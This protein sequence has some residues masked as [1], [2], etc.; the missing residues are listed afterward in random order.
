MVH[1]LRLLRAMESCCQRWGSIIHQLW[2][3]NT[4][5]HPSRIAGRSRGTQYYPRGC[6]SRYIKALSGGAWYGPILK[7]TTEDGML[8]RQQ[9]S[10]CLSTY[11]ASCVERFANHHTPRKLLKQKPQ[12][13]STCGRV[14]RLQWRVFPN[15][16]ESTP[17]QCSFKTNALQDGSK[18]IPSREAL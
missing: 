1:R 10:S 11:R 5:W 7:R 18:H 3:G 2:D 17:C 16:A 8:R 4:V 13:H 14:R 12:F 6:C 15:R 9:L